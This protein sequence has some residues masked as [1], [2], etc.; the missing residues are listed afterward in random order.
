MGG[1][2]LPDYGRLKFT[3]METCE[4]NEERHDIDTEAQDLTDAIVGERSTLGHQPE[5]RQEIPV[6]QR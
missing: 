5:A 1:T 3:G 4:A 2:G 6:G